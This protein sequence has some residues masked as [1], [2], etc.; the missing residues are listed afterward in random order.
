MAGW[1]GTLK[2]GSGG[3]AEAIQLQAAL[4]RKSAGD[5]SDGHA[6]LGEPLR[7]QRLVAETLEL[8]DELDL[9]RRVR[10][11]PVGVHA[12]TLTT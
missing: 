3:H 1:R 9:G 4:H 5:G 2:V 7:D 6:S 8:L 12:E 11:V 10:R